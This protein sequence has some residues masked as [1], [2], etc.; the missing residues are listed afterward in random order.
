MSKEEYA[1]YVS[2]AEFVLPDYGPEGKPAKNAYVEFLWGLDL[3]NQSEPFDGL[4]PVND[5]QVPKSKPSPNLRH[6]NLSLT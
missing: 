5:L 3:I 4:S 2:A 6:L 1:K